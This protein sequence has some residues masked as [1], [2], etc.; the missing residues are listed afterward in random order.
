MV[1]A[2]L[3]A[4]VAHADMFTF[5]PTPKDLYDLD[6]LYYYKWGVNWTMPSG[7][8]IQSAQLFFDNI[9]N[10]RVETDKLYI[11]LLNSAP[12][13]V[14]VGYDNEGGNNNFPQNSNT[15]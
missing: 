13:G 6:H 1:L 9:D 7:Q 4:A 3:M 14:S 15:K 8:T 11:N 5:S 12:A 2:C 10:W